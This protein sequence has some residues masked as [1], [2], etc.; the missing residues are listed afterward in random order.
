M[1]AMRMAEKQIVRR[2][3]RKIGP[4][5]VRISDLGAT[6]TAMLLNKGRSSS[7]AVIGR[8]YKA[9]GVMACALLATT[10]TAPSAVHLS[11]AD[12][13]RIGR[14]IW[15]NECNGTLA[16]LTAWNLSLIHISEPTRLL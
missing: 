13:M 8:F 7:K 4:G 3:I 9:M 10:I 15:Q 12:A 16:G 1:V 11:S 14:R 5:A 6:G 2:F